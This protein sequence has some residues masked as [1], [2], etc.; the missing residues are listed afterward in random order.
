MANLFEFVNKAFLEKGISIPVKEKTKGEQIYDRIPGAIHPRKTKDPPEDKGN[1]LQIKFTDSSIDFFT[2][3]YSI[4]ISKGLHDISP[5]G[6][7]QLINSFYNK[8]YPKNTDLNSIE[9]SNK[10]NLETKIKEFEKYGEK[11][12]GIPHVRLF[13]AIF[14]SILNDEEE[15]VFETII[16]GGKKRSAKCKGCEFK[17]SVSG[18]DFCSMECKNRYA[19]DY[20]D[21]VL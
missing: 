11:W 19:K 18:Y 13:V 16:Y 15:K 4:Q 20:H 17:L 14:Y 8:R 5:S 21:G 2:E 9:L 12:K 1:I 10:N 7:S 6:V 3:D